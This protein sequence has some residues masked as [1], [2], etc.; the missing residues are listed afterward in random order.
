MYHQHYLNALEVVL[1]WELSEEAVIEALH[2][3]V[4]QNNSVDDVGIWD[5]FQSRSYSFN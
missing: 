4:M 2:H 3:Q 5:D 1:A